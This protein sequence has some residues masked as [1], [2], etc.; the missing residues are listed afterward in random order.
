MK[1]EVQIRR[2][3]SHDARDIVGVMRCAFIQFKKYYTKDAY[4]A[5]TPRY[6]KVLIRMSEAPVWVATSGSRMVGTV[7]AAHQNDELYIRGMAVL[8]S[9]RGV[10]I[11]SLLLESAECY[12][13]QNQCQRVCLS[14]TPFLLAAIRL[15]ER[16]GYQRTND[17]PHNLFGTPLFTREKRIRRRS[18]PTS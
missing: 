18:K 7:S 16:E 2:A 14:T 8:P 17:G 12:A 9:M 4:A 11:G 1:K 13:V 3:T 10:R 15:Y 6:K 5:T